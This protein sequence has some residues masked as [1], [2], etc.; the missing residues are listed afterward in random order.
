MNT[1]AFRVSGFG[2]VGPRQKEVI[3][4]ADPCDWITNAS[5]DA[6]PEDRHETNIRITADLILA[7]ND[8]NRLLR[9]GAGIFH[10]RQIRARLYYYCNAPKTASIFLR[11]SGTETGFFK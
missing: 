1:V 11:S 4:T 7:L 10:C 3:H 6:G 9:A 2:A 8:V 5:G